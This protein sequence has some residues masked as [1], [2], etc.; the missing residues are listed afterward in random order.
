MKNTVFVLIASFLCLFPTLCRAGQ[1][2]FAIIGDTRVGSNGSV[3]EAFIQTV[4]KEGINVIVHTGDVIDSP[5]KPDLWSRFLEITGYGKTLYLAPGNHDIKD[6]R[7]LDVYLGFFRDPYSSFSEGDTLFILLNTELPGQRGRITGQQYEWLQTELRRSFRYKFVFLHQP[8]FPTMLGMP[9][10]LDQGKR[11]RRE[12][13]ELFVKEGVSVVVAGHEH[14]Y[15]RHEKDGIE[16]II[17]GGGG[18][19]ILFP[20]RRGGFFHYII[21]KRTDEGYSF[22]AKDIGGSV[23]D[24]FTVTR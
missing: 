12:L 22:A 11:N 7:S 19:P 4:E 21:A 16:Y 9:H 2:P 15:R 10:P 17:S 23:R 13:H 14:L 1:Q 24:E 8:V 6:R 18:A 5:G 20:G 3:Y